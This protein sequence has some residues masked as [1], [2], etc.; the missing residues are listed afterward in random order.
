MLGREIIADRL[1]P[2]AAPE[3]GEAHLSVSVSD[4]PLRITA[5]CER[6]SYDVIW[7]HY[8]TFRVIPV[9]RVLLIVTLLIFLDLSTRLGSSLWLEA[10]QMDRFDGVA[11]VCFNCDDSMLR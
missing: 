6:H 10:A 9:H 1:K 7:S 5:P 2:V 3:A 8:T 4:M 11:H